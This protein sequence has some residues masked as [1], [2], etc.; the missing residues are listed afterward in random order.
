MDF[1]I[2]AMFALTFAAAPACAQDAGTPAP[3][4]Q[5]AP[6]RFDVMAYQVLGNTQLQPVEIERAVYPYLGPQRTEADVDGARAA[7]QKLYD[8]KGFPTVS[9]SVP[10]QDAAS[11]L[12]TLQVSEQR[13]GRLRVV[14]ADY[15][16]PDA[17]ARGAPSLKEGGVP[18]FKDVQRDIVA[19][20]Q[21]PD[22]RVTPEIKP[23]IGPNTV[24]VDLT[25]DDS[26]PLHGSLELN[27]RNSAN[28]TDLRLNATLRYD[29]LWQRGHSLSLSAQ[30]APERPSD[31]KVFS[32]S[33][34]ARLTDSPWSLLAYAVR[35]DSDIAVIS[36]FSVIGNGTLAGVRAIR[37]LPA[38]EGFF[39]SLS[40]GVDYKHFEEE[41]DF[42]AS[43]D[44][45]PIEY[46]PLNLAYNADWVRERSRSSF[47]ATLAANP[48]GIGIGDG[49][50]GKTGCNPPQPGSFDYKRYNAR[51]NFFHLRL[52]GSHTR[53]LG[54]DFQLFGRVQTQLSTEPLI[55]NEQTS[56]G[57][58]DTVR[59]YKESEALGDYGATAQ[60]ELR[61]PSFAGWFGAF[62]QEARARAFVDGGYVRIHKPLPEQ[63]PSETLVSVG[64]GASV[65]VFDHFNGSLD[66]AA[67]L[68][69][70]G[71]DKAPKQDD[72]NMLFRLWGEF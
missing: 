11:G 16:S 47:G 30:T 58:L 31:A 32:A 53:T 51:P 56:I 62:M 43:S 50:C 29:N 42:G 2:A 59:G 44:S 39:H 5:A 25:V 70:P 49:R 19:L 41:S 13:I 1:R 33:Y 72:F 23:G 66:L 21:L 48:G 8:D 45:S 61:S 27:N 57:G 52:E 26:L 36:D 6:R 22:R 35:S 60:L 46:Y 69:R 40:L 38:R 68:S 54:E 65:K 64:I 17:V 18:N 67:P 14:G 34:L 9:V 28:T 4:G 55:S 10:E 24:D 7:L 71:G 20:N 12:V 3:D 37:A 63:L 15:F